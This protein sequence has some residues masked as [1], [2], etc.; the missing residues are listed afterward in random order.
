MSSDFSSTATLHRSGA[1]RILFVC[2]GNI[3]RSPSAE[4][5]FDY[6]V[7]IRKNEFEYETDS[8]GTADYHI[9]KAPDDRAITALKD[10]DLDISGLRCRQVCLNDFY[11]FDFIVAMD[12][13][14]KHSLLDT[15][16]DGASNRVVKMTDYLTNS[17]LDFVQ[18]PFH[19]VQKDFGV[20]VDCLFE[21][22]SA[23]LEHIDNVSNNR[24]FEFIRETLIM[25]GNC[26]SHFKG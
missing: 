17:D 11:E 19:G 4:R 9:G 12:D 3:C 10:Q 25:C 21:C 22:C 18:D 14:T 6:L 15:C 26:C 23:M 24:I 8:A 5:I 7:S 2:L 16:P 1:T 20:M 13:R